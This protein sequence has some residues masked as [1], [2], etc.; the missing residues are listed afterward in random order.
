MKATFW[1]VVILLSLLLAA[2]L[3]TFWGWQQIGEVEMSRHGL[4]ALALGVVISF[5]VGA[6][7]MTLVFFS[8]RR[9]YDDAAHHGER[10]RHDRDA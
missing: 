1:T 7:L 5:L 2:T 8:S 3:V 4:I 6:G 10:D 9:G